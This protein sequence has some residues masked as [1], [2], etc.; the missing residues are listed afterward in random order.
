[1]GELIF[2]QDLSDAESEDQFTDDDE[3]PKSIAAQPNEANDLDTNHDS[4][5]AEQLPA[6][7]P[8]PSAVDTSKAVGDADEDDEEE[9]VGKKRKALSKMYDPIKHRKKT[10]RSYYNRGFFF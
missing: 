1:M 10:L 2:C 5:L 4:S 8:V 7:D 3:D 6:D 9:V